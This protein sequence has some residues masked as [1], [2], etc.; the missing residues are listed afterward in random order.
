MKMICNIKNCNKEA[1]N[2]VKIPAL[3]GTFFEFQLCDEHFSSFMESCKKES[4]RSLMLKE[5]DRLKG[6]LR[7]SRENKLEDKKDQEDYKKRVS[8]K[9]LLQL[10]EKEDQE[11]WKKRM[12]KVKTLPPKPEPTTVSKTPPPSK[13][14]REIIDELKDL[15][16]SRERE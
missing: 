9:V 3:G 11:D 8:P 12:K 6:S 13:R 16:E 5:L 15:L 10:L 4:L 2:L 1:K 14:R 7:G